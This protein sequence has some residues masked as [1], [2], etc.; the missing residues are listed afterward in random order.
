[1]VTMNNDCGV[2]CVISYDSY[3]LTYDVC[4]E[5]HASR[6]VETWKQHGGGIAHAQYYAQ[7]Y[8]HNI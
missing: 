3:D 4:G 5:V 7:Y 2:T 6:G 1:M 8:A